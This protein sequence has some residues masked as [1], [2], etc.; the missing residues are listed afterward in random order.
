MCAL[1]TM[2]YWTKAAVNASLKLTTRSMQ[3]QREVVQNRNGRGIATQ[4]REETKLRKLLKADRWAPFGIA[5]I[6]RG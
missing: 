5:R 1:N 2:I 4:K 3:L 6:V